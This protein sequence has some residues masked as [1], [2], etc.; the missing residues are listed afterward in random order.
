MKLLYSLLL[1]MLITPQAQAHF[2][3]C[4][5]MFPNSHSPKV[6]RPHSRELCYQ[7]FAVLYSTETKTPIYTVEKLTAD[8]LRDKEP[9]TNHFHE[10]DK[11]SSRE[12]ST[13][14][15]YARS[16]YD[17]GHMA[18]AGDMPKLQYGHSNE[19]MEESFS[20]ANMV[21]QAP[22]NNRGIWAKSVEMP[23]RKYVKRTN[24]E[25]YVVT[26]PVYGPDHK[27]IGPDQV[28]VPQSLFKLVYDK[29]AGRSWVF[30]VENSNEARMSAPITYEEFVKR[31][32]LRL[33]D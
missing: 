16:G 26:G 9:R 27:S 3:N 25:V 21:P 19:A 17:R 18:P 4:E 11:L 23:T 20:L 6:Q 12:R 15:D 13:L 30:W 28:W 1:A 8:R 31:T 10:E 33:L 29:T 2:G 22:K 14:R 24:H 32:G 7:A 5:A